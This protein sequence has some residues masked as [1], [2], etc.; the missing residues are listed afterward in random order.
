MKIEKSG[1]FLAINEMLYTKLW[2]GSGDIHTTTTDA[3]SKPR[4]HVERVG[5]RVHIQQGIVGNAVSICIDVDLTGQ[6]CKER[7]HI[8]LQVSTPLKDVGEF[9]D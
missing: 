8:A 6:S 2:S 1:A 5:H 3:E 7:K 4:T 9:L